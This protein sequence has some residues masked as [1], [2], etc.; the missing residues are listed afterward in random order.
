MSR[1][2]QRQQFI[3]FARGTA[4]LFVLLSHFGVVY[5][6]DAPG[7]VPKL[8]R[9]VGM[10]A[11][12][13]FV[14]INGILIGFLCRTRPRDFG[15]L[16]V[17][18]ADRGLFL[19]TVGHLLIL[20]SHLFYYPLTFLHMTDT[21]GVCMLIEPWLVSRT[22]PGERVRWAIL[23]YTFSWIMLLWQPMTMSGHFVKESLFGSPTLTFYNYTF[24]LLPWF[25]LGFAA[26]AL[27]DRLGALYLNGSW[28]RMQSLLNRTAVCALI[29]AAVLVGIH[30]AVVRFTVD[31]GPGAAFRLLTLPFQKEPPSPS[32]ILFYGALGLS[33]ISACFFCERRGLLRAVASRTVAFGQTSLVAFVAQY[34]VYY[35]G[36][37][38][39]LRSQLPALPWPVYFLASVVTVGAVTLAWHRRGYN[40]FITTGLQHLVGTR[41]PDVHVFHSGA[42]HV[43]AATVQHEA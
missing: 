12:P 39:I 17:A 8:M 31:D 10:V 29:G 43:G 9:L 37:E 16:R 33:L 30:T 15:R 34:Y 40:R 38:F 42:G 27:G 6:H 7:L 18:F 24:P 13:T 1:G 35:L 26:S 41:R 32:Y 4:M 11:S 21:L 25:S 19:L 23:V 2:S 5:F 20:G 3:D 14:I 28:D 22:Q 36:L